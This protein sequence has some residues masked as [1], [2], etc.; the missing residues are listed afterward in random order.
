MFF[1]S[2]DSELEVFDEKYWLIAKEVASI[3]ID[4][5]YNI[6]FAYS[7]ANNGGEFE[8]GGILEKATGLK[9]ELS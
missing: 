6:E 4:P 2:N 7:L 5:Q 8:I 3:L 9:T 1:I